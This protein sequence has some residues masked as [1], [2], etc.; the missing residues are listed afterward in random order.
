MN[1]PKVHPSA[2]LCSAK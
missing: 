2:I 1:S